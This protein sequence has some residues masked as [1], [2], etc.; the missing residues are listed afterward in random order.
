MLRVSCLP[1]RLQRPSW[2]PTVTASV[3]LNIPRRVCSAAFP[4]VVKVRPSIDPHHASGPGL[5]AFVPLSAR[6]E[7]VFHLRRF[8]DP[9]GLL[10][11]MRCSSEEDLPIMRFTAPSV[12]SRSFST[13]D[14]VAAYTASSAS[15]LQR[16]FFPDGPQRCVA[17]QSVP[18]SSRPETI[19]GR[20]ALLVV[21][22][23]PVR[24]IPCRGLQR[25]RSSRRPQ[26]VERFGESVA[27]PVCVTTVRPARCSLELLS[28]CF[29][30]DGRDT[31]QRSLLVLLP[32]KRTTCGVSAVSAVVCCQTTS[33][34]R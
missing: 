27:S 14:T 3:R 11:V 8:D 19:T 29:G 1:T 30:T 16:M 33:E 17:L 34:W 28:A 22:A 18:L 13:V 12:R 31:P 23:L 6:T 5:S 2:F 9:G 7:D 10:R 32:S 20:G 26:G 4:G 21:G 15:R 24:C 25:P